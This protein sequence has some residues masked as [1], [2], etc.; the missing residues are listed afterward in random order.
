MVKVGDGG[1]IQY[2]SDMRAVVVCRKSSKSVWVKYVSSKLI[3][4]STRDHAQVYEFGA[5]VGA[6]M[7]CYCDKYGYWR[8]VGGGNRVRFDQ[9]FRQ[10]SDP[11]L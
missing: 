5:A 3:S 9:G 2:G 7:R 8:I 11:N 4:G 1:C 6:E 10:Y